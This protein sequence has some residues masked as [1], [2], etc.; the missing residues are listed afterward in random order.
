V[1]HS[2]LR[3][4]TRVCSRRGARSRSH[5]AAETWYVGR[6]ANLGFGMLILRPTH[7]HWLNQE[8]EDPADLCAH[9]PIELTVGGVALVQPSDGDWTV[10]AA[11]LYLLR[12]LSGPHT[13]E[14][15]LGDHLFPCC[16]FTM[17]DVDEPDVVII[18]CLTGMDFDVI[19][20][21]VQVRLTSADDHVHRAPFLEWRDA[22][23]A[24]ADA[25][26]DFYD[27]SAPRQPSTHEDERGL[28]TFW[29]EWERRRASAAA[30]S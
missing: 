19:R 21:D 1:S 16:G 5:H 11:A 3:C 10:S 29:R 20:E 7:L 9:S 17:Y 27:R 13:A 14:S 25:V 23:C 4:P 30:L 22:V 28:R 26:K 18:G 8:V 2:K 24:F 12:T 15:R 6:T